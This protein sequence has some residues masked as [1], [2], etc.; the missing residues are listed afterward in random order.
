MTP[1]VRAVFRERLVW[2]SFAAALFVNVAT[3]AYVSWFIRPTDELLILH[4]TIDFGI[5]FLGRWLSVF[6]VPLIGLLFGI[7]NAVLVWWFWQ[8]MRALAVV[9]LAVTVV[10]QLA[11]G[12]VALLLVALNT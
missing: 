10:I 8:R 9:T 11:L 5:D 2:L 1:S 12:G 7:V 3:L 6:A 4:Y